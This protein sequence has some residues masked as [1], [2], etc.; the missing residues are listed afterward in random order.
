MN[1]LALSFTLL[2]ACSSLALAMIPSNGLETTETA[3]AL[4]SNKSYFI[5]ARKGTV[6][7]TNDYYAWIADLNKFPALATADV[8]YLMAVLTVFPGK[9]F[10]ENYHPRASEIITVTRGAA[11]ISFK[12]E[13][14]R[15]VSNVLRAYQTTVI[16]QG[17]PHVIT[18]VSK[19]WCRGVAVLNSAD[20]G[21]IFTN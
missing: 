7:R 10:P 1:R 4:L 20:P 8:Q 14:G 19:T 17:L 13:N 2:C 16:P 9:T 18:C 12:M 3:R 21:I 6:L 11:R 15:E 5:N